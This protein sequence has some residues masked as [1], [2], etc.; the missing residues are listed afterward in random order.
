MSEDKD[1]RRKSQLPPDVNDGTDAHREPEKLEMTP[2]ETFVTA[3]SAMLAGLLVT[4]I[5]IAAAV[6]FICFCVFVWFR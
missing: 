2:H 4:G 1:D 3:M 5:F 6:A